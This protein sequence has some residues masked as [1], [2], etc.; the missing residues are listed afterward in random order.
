MVISDGR[1]VDVAECG[2]G[3]PVGEPAQEHGG[4]VQEMLPQDLGVGH[5]VGKVVGLQPGVQG[6][7]FVA[8]P[9][10]GDDATG[11]Y[12]SPPPVSLLIP[13]GALSDRPVGHVGAD[14]HDGPLYG[15]FP[16]S[17]VVVV[18]GAG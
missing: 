3:D 8:V 6:D 5:G 9:V 1:A 7:L 2:G 13:A 16:R 17:P 4:V 14:R 18:D 10:G 11:V 12:E 15:L